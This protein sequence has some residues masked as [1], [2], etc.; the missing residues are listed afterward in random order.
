MINLADFRAPTSKVYKTSNI[1]KFMDNMILK[2]YMYMT[3]LIEEYLHPFRG[4]WYITM[5]HTEDKRVRSVVV[6]DE[7]NWSYTVI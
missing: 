4:D 6:C 3:A 1:L 7:I 2:N 5:L